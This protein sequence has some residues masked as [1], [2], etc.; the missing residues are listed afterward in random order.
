VSVI[1]N[2]CTVITKSKN[3]KRGKYETKDD[4]NSGGRSGERL[5]ARHFHR[6]GESMQMTDMIGE[7]A[8]KR[9]ST[10]P[11]DSTGPEL[12]GRS[13]AAV[14]IIFFDGNGNDTRAQNISRNGARK[15]SGMG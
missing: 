12:P 4:F 13:L 1:R 3:T 6:S 15:S 8:Q 14:G 9:L 7:P 11:M 5:A 2:V 10:A